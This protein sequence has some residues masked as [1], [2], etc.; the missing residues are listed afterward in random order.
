[1]RASY[2]EFKSDGTEERVYE[3]VKSD[4]ITPCLCEEDYNLAQKIL[5]T[6][7]NSKEPPRQNS[8]SFLLSGLL[9]C[10]EC[11]K[12][13]L[14]RNWVDKYTRKDGTLRISNYRAY[15]CI[16]GQSGKPCYTGSIKSSELENAVITEVAK[17]L[18]VLDLERAVAEAESQIANYHSE[19][20]NAIEQKK[21]LLKDLNGRINFNHRKLEESDSLKLQRIYQSRIQKLIDEVENTTT[22]LSAFEN[23]LS[24]LVSHKIEKSK[25]YEKLSKWEELFTEAPLNTKRTM[26][27]DVVSKVEFFHKDKLL[28][29]Y[30]KL[31]NTLISYR[32]LGDNSDRDS[33]NDNG[34]IFNI[35][36]KVI[37]VRI[38]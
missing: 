36:I 8:T 14:C 29:I 19:L 2:I 33:Y 35:I 10:G 12:P 30:L 9:V 5:A 4:K 31:D 27:L 25:L 7:S 6:R 18:S 13:M 16:T 17:E 11:G 34:N 23:A 37:E 28:R 22:S 38:K 21:R 20:A 3:P 32:C 24:E 1:M 15:R 26:L